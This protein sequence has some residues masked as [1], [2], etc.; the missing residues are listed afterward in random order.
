MKNFKEIL[1]L[2]AAEMNQIQ[3]LD[4]NP[5]LFAKCYKDFYGDNQ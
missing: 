2:M 5:K 3:L 4:K 1:H